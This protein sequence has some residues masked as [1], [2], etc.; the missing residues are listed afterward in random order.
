MK[1]DKDLCERFPAVLAWKLLHEK[2]KLPDQTEFEYEPIQVYRAVER[3]KEDYTEVNQTDFYSYYELN[4]FPKNK[5]IRGK[6]DISKDPHYYGVSSFTKREI[7]EQLMKFP[8]PRKKMAEGYVYQ[9]GGPQ[10]TN[11]DTEHVCWWLY[12]DRKVAG[13]QLSEE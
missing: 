4:K 6:G 8:N 10:E 11:W 9:E 5:K 3:K 12:R 7:V 2:V 13:F 1:I